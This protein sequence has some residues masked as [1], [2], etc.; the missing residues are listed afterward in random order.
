MARPDRAADGGAVFVH[1]ADGQQHPLLDGLRDGAG[2]AVAA[3]VADA[4]GVGH[5]PGGGPGL[6]VG[7]DEVAGFVVLVEQIVGGVERLFGAA[8]GIEVF[9]RGDGLD[10]RLAQD[11][12]V[13]EGVVHQFPGL[14][15]E[16]A[17]GLVFGL[18]AG[19]DDERGDQ[20]I[21][22]GAVDAAVQLGRG[23]VERLARRGSDTDKGHAGSCLVQWAAAAG[24]GGPGGVRGGWPG[25]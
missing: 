6:A 23:E 21:F 17:S 25:A 4:H 12:G 1:G 22:V 15:D 24:D 20:R 13:R 14:R 2:E 11:E 7:G 10:R 16:G 9:E 8:G 5:R 19:G 3:D 18:L